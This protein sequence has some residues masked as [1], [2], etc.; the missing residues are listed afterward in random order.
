MRGVNFTA[1]AYM[2]R[3]QTTLKHEKAESQYCPRTTN[4]SRQQEQAHNAPIY[5]Y[6]YIYTADAISGRGGAGGGGRRRWGLQ[7]KSGSGSRVIEV[8]RTELLPHLVLQSLFGDK[9]LKLQVLRRTIVNRTYGTH[10]NLY[11]C[12][13]IFTNNIWSYLSCG[14]P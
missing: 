6:I 9:P 1:S 8:R 3:A 11:K 4:R 13:R 12:F 5:I 7:K 10:K 2:A 14:P